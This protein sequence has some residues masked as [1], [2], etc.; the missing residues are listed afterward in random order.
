VTIRGLN[1]VSI[2]PSATVS[3]ELD[4]PCSSASWTTATKVACAAAS[5]GLGTSR[6]VVT[7]GGLVGT[8][9]GRWQFSY[10]APAVSFTRGANGA[11]TG[12]ATVTVGGLNFASIDPSA[13]VSLE[14]YVPC[15]SASWTSAT[16]LACV[17]ASYGGGTSRTA[18]AVG[19]LV[20]TLRR[21][22]SFDGTLPAM[23]APA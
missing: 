20:T 2:D 12:G 18:V 23:G 22:F 4:V 16:T 14:L 3:L 8:L 6:T 11:H 19:K 7:V 17:A 9:L 5:Y 10:D 1:F 21:Q 15:S 13:T